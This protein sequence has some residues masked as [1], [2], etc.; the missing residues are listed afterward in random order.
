MTAATPAAGYE[1]KAAYWKH[2][3]RGA[4]LERAWNW[5]EAYF[6]FYSKFSTR[7]RVMRYTG[8]LL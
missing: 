4:Y 2:N 5:L 6:I 8:N 7:T 3:K 1:I